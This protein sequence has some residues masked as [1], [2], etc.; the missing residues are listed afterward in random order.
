MGPE[1]GERKGA[2]SVEDYTVGGAW[3][4]TDR[5]I[6]VN[7][8]AGN[9]EAQANSPRVVEQTER[10]APPRSQPRAYASTSK[11]LGRSDAVVTGT[12]S[13]LGHFAFTLFDSSST[14]FFILC[15]LLY[16]QGSN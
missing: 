1:E 10:P 13:I 6:N 15:L 12:L 9:T 16:K 14:H 5:V 3:L 2:L 8:T 4:A 11:D 7:C